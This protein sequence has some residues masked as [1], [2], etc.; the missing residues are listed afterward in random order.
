MLALS[1]VR[2]TITQVKKLPMPAARPLLLCHTVHD[3]LGLRVLLR[4]ICYENVR[5]FLRKQPV[6]WCGRLILMSNEKRSSFLPVTAYYHLSLPAHRRYR[7]QFFHQ[8]AGAKDVFHTIGPLYSRTRN[9]FYRAC[10]PLFPVISNGGGGMKP[11]F[12]VK[13]V[14]VKC[15]RCVNRGYEE[16]DAPRRKL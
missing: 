8:C 3:D 15:Y 4:P 2:S 7:M 14:L 13:G 6:I 10:F 1:A 16:P 5:V 12:S 9:L 11:L